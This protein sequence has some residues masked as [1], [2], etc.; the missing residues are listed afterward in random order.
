MSSLEPGIGY[1]QIRVHDF[2]DFN[3]ES[4]ITYIELIESN[5]GSCIT[6]IEFIESN[7]GSC[8]AYIMHVHVKHW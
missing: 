6:Y 5:V 7:V 1:T 3:V 8:I 4:C 2:I